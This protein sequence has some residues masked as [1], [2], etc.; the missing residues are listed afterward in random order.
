MRPIVMAGA[1]RMLSRDRANWQAIVDMLSSHEKFVHELQRSQW[2]SASEIALSQQPRLEKLMRHAAAEVPYYSTRLA[3]L[4][5]DSDPASAP[6]DLSRWH[7]LPILT[8]ADIVAKG[9]DLIARKT[10]A[11][12]GSS[13]TRWSSGTTNRPLEFRRCALALG[14]SNCQLHRLYELHEF[15]FSGRFALITHDSRGSSSYPDGLKS[16]GWNF[17]DPNA[18]MFSL[19]IRTSPPDQLEW[20]ERVKPDYV[21]TYPNNLCAVAEAAISRGSKFKLKAFI[22]TG[23]VLD[24]TAQEQ[25]ARVFDCPVLDVY[26]AREAGP[27]AF[28]CPDGEAYHVCAE[29]VFCEILRDNGEPAAPGEQGRIVITPLFEFAMPFVRYDLG[30]FAVVS[31]EPCTCGRG[32]PSLTKIAGRSRHLFMMPDG[33]RFWPSLGPISKSLAKHLS[34]RQIQFIQPRIGLLEL[35][36]VPE[37]ASARPNLEQIENALRHEFH[38]GLE[39]RLN[40][41][42]RIDRGAGMKL[43]QFVSLIAS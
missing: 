20:L 6:I 32:L 41:V 30:D 3:P 16:M 28:R 13:V 5:G 22:A 42:D 24:N 18:D 8:R 9:Y 33:S 17:A 21:M 12:A 29:T 2:L 43:E 35:K 40:P 25:I 19:E 14:V 23:E 27:I 4:F 31:G 36:Y 11:E 39:V 34:F 7:Q 10:P 37:D 15:D 38:A 1:V 26:G